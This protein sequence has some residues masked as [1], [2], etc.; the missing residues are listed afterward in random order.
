MEQ[1]FPSAFAQ[2]KIYLRINVG[3]YIFR[4]FMYTIQFETVS[5]NKVLPEKWKN[6]DVQSAIFKYSQA[7]YH[8]MFFKTVMY[9]WASMQTDAAVRNQMAYMCLTFEFI[10]LF[11]LLKENLGVSKSLSIA[12]LPIVPRVLQVLTVMAGLLLCNDWS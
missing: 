9:G 11:N 1:F 2:S 3:L 7:V 6:K 5:R 8:A 10:A 4:L 12:A